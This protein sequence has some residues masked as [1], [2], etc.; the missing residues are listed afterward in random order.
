M[1][2]VVRVLTV[3][4]LHIPFLRHFRNVNL[5]IVFFGTY[6]C[7]VSLFSKAKRQ[8]LTSDCQSWHSS[9][10]HLPSSGMTT[11]KH[12]KPSSSSRR[13]LLHRSPPFAG[14]HPDSSV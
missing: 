14:S 8:L 6:R 12:F 11:R 1:L 5:V 3:D 10:V 9:T 13:S 2:L 7:I 4:I